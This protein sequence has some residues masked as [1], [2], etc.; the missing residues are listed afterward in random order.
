MYEIF[1]SSDI[2]VNV[3]RDMKDLLALTLR[4]NVFK[5]LVK[6]QRDV[7]LEMIPLLA[8]VKRVLLE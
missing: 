8:S 6:M 7:Y 4:T 2:N 1:L 5:S 3:T